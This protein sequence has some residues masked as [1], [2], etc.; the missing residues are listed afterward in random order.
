MG[1]WRALCK[2]A[3][4]CTDSHAC[5]RSCAFLDFV[6]IFF[7]WL[8]FCKEC[9]AFLS[10]FPFFPKNFRGVQRRKIH[11]FLWFCLPFSK[12]QG[13]EAQSLASRKAPICAKRNVLRSA[14]LPCEHFNGF[15]PNSRR[16]S[17]RFGRFSVIFNHFRSFSV[18]FNQF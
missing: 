10:V 6:L 9:L 15:P 8:L 11:I 14:H 16:L 18:G 4:A 12:R 2:V 1:V 7:S 5:E 3:H 17:I 13:K